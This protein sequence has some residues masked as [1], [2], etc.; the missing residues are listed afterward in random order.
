M[1]STSKVLLGIVGAAAAGVVIGLLVAPE[2]GSE[3]RSKINEKTNGLV[4]QL[5]GLFTGNRG[6]GSEE[7][8]DVEKEMP[9][10]A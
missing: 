9:Q 4:D 2:K 1:T 8:E 10:G 3:F 7:N 5:T 6:E